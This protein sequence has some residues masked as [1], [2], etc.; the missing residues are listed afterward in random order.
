MLLS[1]VGRQAGIIGTLMKGWWEE[2]G[3]RGLYFLKLGPY[4]GH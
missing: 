3:G 2:G 1:D 4:Y